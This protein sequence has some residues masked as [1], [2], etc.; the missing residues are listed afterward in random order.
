M[1]ACS[2]MVA[3]TNEDPIDNGNEN[4]GKAEAYMAIRLVN[5]NGTQSRGDNGNYEYGTEEENNVA[6]TTFYFFKADGSASECVTRTLSWT[7][8]TEI[9]RAHV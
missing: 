3:C 5:A 8:N 2:A 1:L 7:T 4:G 9:G 6:T